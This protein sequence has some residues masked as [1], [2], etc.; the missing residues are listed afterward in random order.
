MKRALVTGAS[1]FVGMHLIHRLDQAGVKTHAFVRSLSNFNTHSS[2][3]KVIG[4][5]VRD[6]TSLR[7]A[8]AGCDVVFHLAARAHQTE[9]FADYAEHADITVG[10]TQNALNAAIECG[11][12]SFV[13][14]SSLSVHGP[15]SHQMLD[16]SAPRRPL[17]PYGRA[18]FEAEEIVLA[19]G[20]TV[21]MRVSCLRP[22]LVYGVGCK[23]NLPKMIQMIDRGLF[24]PIPELNNRRSII[25]VSNLID[26]LLLVA[27]SARSAGECYIATDQRAYSTRNLYELISKQLG[28]KIPSWTV[29]ISVLRTLGTAGDVI[30]GLR[31]KRFMFDSDALEKLTGSAWY[32]SQKIERELGYQPRMTL[33]ASLPELID[34]Y[35]KTKR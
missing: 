16:E 1:G 23:G 9:E 31:K 32:S 13:F 2:N 33:E 35:R 19:A 24:P 10:G 17:T 11:A 28:K 15:A 8:A 7:S 29:P 21:R 20:Q 27:E 3:V 5:D 22:P 26:A 34:D 25:H 4:G 30:G 6:L 18:K 14:V 12:G